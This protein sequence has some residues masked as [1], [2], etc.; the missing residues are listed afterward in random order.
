[1]LRL[2]IKELM[3]EKRYNTRQ[4]SQATGIRWNTVDDM[5]NNR[6]KHWLPEN[7]EKIYK[8]M[9]L[10]SISELLEYSEGGE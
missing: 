2:K 1:M 8:V 9:G 7:L 3:V 10:T 6:A 4:L 5:V